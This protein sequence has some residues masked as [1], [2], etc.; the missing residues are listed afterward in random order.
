MT[1]RRSMVAVLSTAVAVLLLS[2]C[3]A[4]ADPAVS[5][6][7]DAAGFWQGLWQGFISPFAFL[8]SLFRD[9]VGIYEVNNNGH[10]YDFGFM[11]GVSIIFGGPARGGAYASN[12]RRSRKAT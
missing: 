4:G 10:W 8:V 12:R 3:A 11:I 7:P 1:R 2:A 6:G 9:D 5:S